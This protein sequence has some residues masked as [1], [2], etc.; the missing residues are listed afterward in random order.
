MPDTAQPR[1][2]WLDP[3]LYR[4]SDHYATVADGRVHYLDE[5]AGPVLLMLHGNP[6]W[7]FLYRH[8]IRDLSADFR[9]VAVDYPGFGLSQDPSGYRFRASDH[10]TVVAELVTRLGLDDIVLVAGDWGGPIGLSAAATIP[11]RFT[12][13]V[14]TNTWA[15][16]TT[17]RRR[18]LS[19]AAGGP[20]GRLLARRWNLF[21]R[22]A[23]PASHHRTRLSPAETAYYL[24]PFSTPQRRLPTALFAWQ[25]TAARDSL[26]GLN[27]E[28]TPAGTTDADRVGPP[29]SSVRRAGPLRLEHL[30][31][32]HHGSAGPRRSPGA[33]RRPRRVHR[34]DSELDRLRVPD[35]TGTI[36]TLGTSARTP[37]WLDRPHLGRAQRGECR[38]AAVAIGWCFRELVAANGCWVLRCRARDRLRVGALPRSAG[39]ERTGLALAS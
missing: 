7:S 30:F 11:E 10:A 28:L 12:G 2:E 36:R 15:W 29:R 26:A 24:N 35:L 33:R 31:T 37:R 14:L 4:F 38:A 18:L 25:L 13:L 21:A 5:G 22:L 19:W 9:C 39:S 20:T 8:Q 27:T 23:I 17:G 1:P 6:T 16:P 32:R 34:S 3:A